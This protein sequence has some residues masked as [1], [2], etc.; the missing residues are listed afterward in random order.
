MYLSR[1]FLN[2]RSRLVQ[3]DLTAHQD[4]HRTVLS[5]FPQLPPDGEQPDGRQ[6]DARQH[7]GVLHRLDSDLNGGQMTLLIQSR[8][9]PDFSRL[10]AGYLLSSSGAGTPMADCKPL[11]ER[12]QKIATG[13]TLAFRLRAN[14]TRKIDTK[15][16]PDGKRRNGKRVDLRNE[17]EWWA[18]LRRKGESHGFR[19]LTIHGSAGNRKAPGAMPVPTVPNTRKTV[20]TGSAHSEHGRRLTFASVL[21]EGV[22]EVT[23]RD[24]FL[25]ALE[26][27]VGAGK[28]Y[29]FGLL[30][31]APAHTAARI[32][33]T[34]TAAHAA[35]PVG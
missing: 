32:P 3:R 10:P 16:G 22:L 15:S 19:P 20:D 21:F 28:A 11:E 7:F 25:A 2:P 12:Y 35:T 24:V 1:L 14:P 33:A 31:V 6:A 30:S 29:G 9:E 27:G 34:A 13:M 23:D 5:L 17:E 26:Q 4:M 8:L 18:W